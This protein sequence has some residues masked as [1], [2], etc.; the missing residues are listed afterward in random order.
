V[1][2]EGKREMQVPRRDDAAAAQLAALPADEVLDGLAGQ[3]EGA[4]EAEAGIWGH[5]SAAPVTCLSQL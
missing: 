1:A 2:E 3:T 5:A 4:K